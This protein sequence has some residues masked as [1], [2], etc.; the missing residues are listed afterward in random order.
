MDVIEREALT[1][2]ERARERF[3]AGEPVESGVR[4]WVLTSW[5]RSR[6]MGVVPYQMPTVYDP[7]V[8]LHGRLVEAAT[9]VLDQLESRLSG[10][11]VAAVLGDAHARVLQRRVGEPALNRWLTDS[12]I[13]PGFGFPEQAVGTNGIGTALAERRPV[14]VWGREHYAEA[15]GG[16]VCAASPIRDPISGRVEGVLNLACLE[17]FADPAML[18]VAVDATDRIEERLLEQISQR[19]QVLL[20]AFLAARRRAGG[21]GAVTLRPLDEAGPI[22]SHDRLSLLEKATELISASHAGMAVVLLSGG[23]AATLISR[24]IENPAG[25]HG[26]AVEAILTDGSF[27]HVASGSREPTVTELTT[28]E[29]TAPAKPT[30]AGPAHAVPAS[31]LPEVPLPRAL[32]PV[33]ATE[34]WLLAV[35]E[36]GVGRLA[37][38]ARERLSL[39]WEACA[40]VGTSLEVTRTAQELTEVAVPRFADFVAVDLPDPVL[41][42]DEPGVLDAGLRRIALTTTLRDADLPG[43]GAPIHPHPATPQGRCLADGQSVLEPELDVTLWWMAQDPEHSRKVH[44]QGIHSLIVVPMRARDV[45]LGVVSFYRSRRMSAFEE[46]DLTLAEELVGRAAV[47]VDN[48]RRYTHEHTMSAELERAAESLKQSLERQR[49]FTTDASHELRTPLAGLRAQLEE[50]QLHPGETDLTELLGHTLGDVDRL[51]AI[52]TDLLLLAQLE[53]VPATAFER[54]DLA[55]V[56]EAEVSRQFG[57]RCPARLD[58]EPGVVVDAVPTQIRRV[59]GNLLDNARRHAAHSVV[60][61]VSRAGDQAELSVIDDGPGVPEAQREDIFQ[62]FARLDTAR[63]RGHGGTGLGLAIA[64]DIAHVHQGTLHVEEARPHGAHFI[65]RLPLAEP[66]AAEAGAANLGRGCTAL[67]LTFAYGRYAGRA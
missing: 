49:R 47:C 2:L 59:L 57:D 11:K 32:E 22:A 36:P 33:T 60:V 39:I 17:R 41:R 48:A 64:R 27:W 16:L 4:P 66:P 9:P 14:L 53:A 13:L 18:G 40:R 12:Q 30:A 35:G 31:L 63:G 54:V 62:R 26:I 20:G 10:I 45:T 19:E 65:F 52:I 34:R 24:P 56:V 46:D 67:L 58:L 6:H 7:D 61:R 5:E 50:A 38:Q 25:T 3:H 23:R 44:E 28:A 29:P 37:V 55:E 42:G 51:Q 15:M 21:A 43:V 1:A 8:D